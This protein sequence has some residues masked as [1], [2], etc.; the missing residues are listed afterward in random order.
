VQSQ[1]RPFAPGLQC[2][3]KAVAI[4]VSKSTSQKLRSGLS[5]ETNEVAHGYPESGPAGVRSPKGRVGTA[6]T[7][8]AGSILLLARSSCGMPPSGTG[9]RGARTPGA[10]DSRRLPSAAVAAWLGTHQSE[11]YLHLG[12]AANH[13]VCRG[14]GRL[15]G[16]P[17]ADRMSW[18]RRLGSP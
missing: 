13:A 15:G 11:G 3:I 9:C 18:N 4:P 12:S 16:A 1:K 2:R 8:P 6:E 5:S 10:A 7:R 17:L 14:G